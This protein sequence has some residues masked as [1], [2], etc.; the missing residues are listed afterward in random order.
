M[1]QSINQP[2]IIIVKKDILSK[3]YV[4]TD[5]FVK[6]YKI[7]ERTDRYIEILRPPNRLTM[8]SGRVRTL[9]QI[10]LTSGFRSANGVSYLASDKDWEENKA[11][12]LQ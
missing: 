5:I 7:M 2:E 12:Q 11:K 4:L 3:L 1:P 6:I 8:Y 9:H 10:L